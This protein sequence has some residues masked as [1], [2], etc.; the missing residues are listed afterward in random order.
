[1]GEGGI[2]GDE[3]GGVRPGDQALDFGEFAR[4]PIGLDEQVRAA[5]PVELVEFLEQFAE[6]LE[7]AGGCWPDVEAK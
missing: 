3:D 2:P 1:M 4:R 7:I 5:T 6:P